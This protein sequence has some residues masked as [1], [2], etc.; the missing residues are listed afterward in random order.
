MLYLWVRAT[1]SWADEQAFRAQL[2]PAFAAKVAVWNETFTL[3]YHLFRHQVREIARLNLSRVE[4]AV[5]APWEEIPDGA[6]VAPVDDD[7]W[8]APD[9]AHAL[10]G[11]H[12][13]EAIGYFWTS[14]F[15]EVPIDFGHRLFL[16]RRALFPATPP[17]W[18]CATNSYAALKRPDTELL[19]Q[20]HTVASARFAAADRPHV[21]R[22]ERRLSLMNRT[23]ASQ[24]SLAF[25][26]PTIR[27]R[28]LLRKHRAYRKLYERPVSGELA[29]SVPYVRSMADLMQQ[30]CVK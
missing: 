21:R 18:L 16:L 14:S 25:V 6:L 12:D 17:R 24:T 4:G 10:A 9:L 8:F 30:L 13:R 22:L 11:A 19:L 15:L 20:K 28:E 26:R 5:V 2:D 27:R 3:P 23:L 7:D 29:W 1:A